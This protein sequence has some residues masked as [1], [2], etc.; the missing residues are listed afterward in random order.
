MLT[1][2]VN[3]RAVSA[4]LTTIPPFTSRALERLC[5]KAFILS[6]SAAARG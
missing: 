5:P 6:L 3:S 2:R 1:I 4:M